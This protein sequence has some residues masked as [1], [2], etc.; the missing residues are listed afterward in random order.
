MSTVIRVASVVNHV[1]VPVLKIRCPTLGIIRYRGCVYKNIFHIQNTQTRTH[2]L[3][4]Q[5]LTI[6][7]T[8]S[9]RFLSHCAKR[10]VINQIKY[11]YFIL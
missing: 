4:D 3:Y 5:Y 7:T 6:C 9:S 2:Y 1:L 8:R 10:D 11:F